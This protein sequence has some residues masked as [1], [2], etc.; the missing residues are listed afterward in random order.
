MPKPKVYVTRE[1]PERGLK[2]IKKYFDTE[3]WTEYAPPPKKLIIEKAK[4]VDAL[5]SLLSDKIDAEV[6]DAAPKLK[7]VAQMA[8]GF[9]NI[10]VQ[11]ATKRGIYV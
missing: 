10:D 3:V 11:E 5:A 9:D 6:F 1:L 2:I 8:V 4:N 7:I